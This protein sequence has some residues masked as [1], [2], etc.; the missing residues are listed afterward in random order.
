MSA[1]VLLPPTTRLDIGQETNCQL[2][3]TSVT[4]TRPPDHM[5]RCFAAVAP[6]KPPPTTTTLPTG[7][8]TAPAPAHA[9][10]SDSVV[11]AVAKRSMSRLVNACRCIIC[12]PPRSSHRRLTREIL[13]D[14]R[15]LLVA[16][17]PGDLVHDRRRTLAHAELL[18]LLDQIALR[19]PGKTR[20]RAG[21][22]TLRSVTVR[23]RPREIESRRVACI[24]LCRC[25]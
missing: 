2:G 22:A 24:R 5:R 12:R 18:H 8:K 20:H 17:T 7:F 1:S 11:L 4:A 9:D 21:A 6:P 10:S 14:E 25:A 19:Q 3:S 13:G 16:V 15:G 23:A